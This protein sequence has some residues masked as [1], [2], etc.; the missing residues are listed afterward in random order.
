MKGKEAE[1]THYRTQVN[2]FLIL[3]LLGLRRK[4]KSL[5]I[6]TK[7]KEEES[8]H[9]LSHVADVVRAAAEFLGVSD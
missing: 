8:T 2:D 9:L 7:G 4:K 6:I 1:R 3:K 5:T